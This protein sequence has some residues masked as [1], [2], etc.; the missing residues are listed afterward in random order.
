MSST[1]ATGTATAS[2]HALASPAPAPAASAPEPLATPLLQRAAVACLDVD[3]GELIVVDLVEEILQRS[4]DVLFEKHISSQ[5]LPYAVQ[6]AKD[7][8]LRLAMWEFFDEDTVDPSDPMW[9]PD[10]EPAPMPVD[11]WARGVLHLGPEL[12]GLGPSNA[13]SKPVVSWKSATSVAA[14][15]E[16]TAAAATGQPPASPSSPRKAIGEGGTDVSQPGSPSRGQGQGQAIARR[17]S[18]KDW[19]AKPERERRLAQ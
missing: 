15:D 19:A 4:Q 12:Y 6:Y 1:A 9:L 14:S 3:D 10:E 17:D 11:S 13:A 2:T 8:V 7:T 5:V 16:T 18:G